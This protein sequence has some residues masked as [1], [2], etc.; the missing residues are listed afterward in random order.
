MLHGMPQL[1][2]FDLSNPSFCTCQGASYQN[3][4]VINVESIFPV[5]SYLKVCAPTALP[6]SRAHVVPQ[7]SDCRALQI[8]QTVQRSLLA[9][10]TG[11]STNTLITWEV[12][13]LAQLT[14]HLA[15]SA[16]CG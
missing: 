14:E 15:S 3:G 10:L 8:G 16:G 4:G 13:A 9:T 11:K 6:P 7:Q 1:H 5:N 2:D 12:S